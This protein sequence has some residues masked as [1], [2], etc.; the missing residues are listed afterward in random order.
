MFGPHKSA[1]SCNESNTAFVDTYLIY[2]LISY[3][4][5]IAEHGTGPWLFIIFMSLPFWQCYELAMIYLITWW[6]FLFMSFLCYIFMSFDSVNLFKTY[7][8]YWIVVRSVES[9]VK[10]LISKITQLHAKT[11]Y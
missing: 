7:L 10:K 9:I 11:Y 6:S 3:V 2:G 5:Y 4:W 1:L 8:L